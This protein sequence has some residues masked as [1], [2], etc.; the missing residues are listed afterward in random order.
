M[1]CTSCTRCNISMRNQIAFN[2]STFFQL[3]IAEAQVH[4]VT[5]FVWLILLVA[6]LTA[7]YFLIPYTP[8]VFCF[9]R[10]FLFSVFV[11]HSGLL[12]SFFFSFLFH[13]GLYQWPILFILLCRCMESCEKRQKDALQQP[14][15]PQNHSYFVSQAP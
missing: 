6:I 12:F 5:P 8:R 1:L 2:W 13:Q 15:C 7:A 11:L 9:L 10:I 3:G 14:S 4:Q